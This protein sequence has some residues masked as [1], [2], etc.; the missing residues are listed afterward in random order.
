MADNYTTKSNGQISVRNAQVAVVMVPLPAQGHLN[1][2]LHLSRLITSYNIPVHYVG[3]ATHIRQAKFRVHGFDP[4]TAKNLHFYELPTPPS[5]NPP[6]NPNASTKFPNHLIPSF[7][8]TIHLREPVCS[9]VRQLLGANH[10]KVI[11]IYDSMMTWV[12]QDVPAIPNAQC[13]RFNSI[14]AFHTFSYI[15]E[16]RGK[17]FQAGTEIFEDIPSIENCSTPE[18]WE[19]WNKQ[20]SLEG[21][22]SS[23]ELFNSSRVI[24]SLYLDLVAKEI[25]GLNLWAIGP[26]NPLLLTEQHKDSTKRHQTLDWLDKQEPDSVIYVSFGSSTSLSSEEIE[27]LAIGLE[28]SVQKFVWALRDADKGDIFAGEERR[29]RLPEG[30]EE[31]LKGRGIIVRDWAPQLEILEHPSTGGFMSHCGWNSCM[32]SISM[33]VPIAAWPMHSDQPRNAQLVTKF[34]KIGLNVRHWAHGDELVTSQTIE[35]VVRTLM[36][37]PDGDEMRKRASELSIAVKQSVMDG[38]E[39]DSFIAHITR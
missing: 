23:G 32:E 36:A 33:G 8:E 11:V 35:N 13:Y 31:R 10:R 2:L 3:A 19:L 4:V 27:Q 24:E 16:S 29:A 14:S 18:L 15:W 28:K 1:Q 26:F 34:L 17:P 21:K 25:N 20:Q 30:Y 38:G 22:I 37:S 6:P 5:E 12:V 9:L 7:Y 39:M